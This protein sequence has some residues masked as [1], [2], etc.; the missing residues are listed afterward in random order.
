MEKLTC[1]HYSSPQQQNEA[2]KVGQKRLN[3]SGSGSRGKKRAKVVIAD[4]RRDENEVPVVSNGPE[5]V[6]RGVEH[7][8]YLDE[9]DKQG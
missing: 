2:E 9:E 7:F 1:R 6:G 4:G 8:C 3:A 5:L